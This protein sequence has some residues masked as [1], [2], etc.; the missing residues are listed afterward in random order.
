[1][2]GGFQACLSTGATGDFCCRLTGVL[3]FLAEDGSTSCTMGSGW[4]LL[5]G[6]MKFKAS[7]FWLK[8]VT[9]FDFVTDVSDVA[10][11]PDAAEPFRCREDRLPDLEDDFN[12][13]IHFIYFCFSFFLSLLSASLCSSSCWSFCCF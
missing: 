12:D 10:D 2:P 7:L 9:E 6:G 11:A 3:I 4:E 5:S 1:M 8:R 13:F